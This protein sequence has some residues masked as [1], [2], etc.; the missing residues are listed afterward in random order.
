MRDYRDYPR[1]YLN[2]TIEMQTTRAENA[3]SL[4]H[5]YEKQWFRRLLD[6]LKIGYTA[7][8][9]FNGYNKDVV[10]IAY[11]HLYMSFFD[12][13]NH[14]NYCDGVDYSVFPYP[15]EDESVSFTLR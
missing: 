15:I 13:Y 8:I 12:V 5:G 7:R 4:L 10:A 9:K 1:Q 6:L 11:T 14:K 3:V 2:D